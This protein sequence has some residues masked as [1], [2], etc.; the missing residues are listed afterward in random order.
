MNFNMFLPG[1]KDVQIT[2]IEEKES[3][4]SVHLQM[5]RQTQ[6]C[7]DCGGKTSKIHDYRIQKIKH[8]KWFE[9]PTYLFYKRRRYRCACGKRFAET[10]PFVERYQ[11]FSEEGNQA[12][13]IRS[14]KA[15]TFKEAAEVMGTSSS[16]VIRRFEQV[17]QK[18]LAAGV[19]LPKVIAI[20]EYKGDTN[21]GKFQLIVAN[22]ET[23][24]PLDILP[25]R[26]KET[27]KA[28]LRKYGQN[29][30][31]VV[32]DMSTSFRAAVREALGRPV[33][34]ADR[35]HY[36]RYIY[37]ALDKVRRDV[38]KD[39]HAY[40]RKKCKKMRHVF[41]KRPEKLREEDQFYLTRYLE[42]SPTLKEAYELKK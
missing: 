7:P 6:T 18:E 13:C 20:D 35:F 41:Y 14:I 17:A 2:S 29:V 42:M 24:E 11:R 39:W 31:M 32:M 36:C 9:R 23:R 33:I 37:W 5:P 8:L 16:T 1:M 21:E 19:E 27:I 4:I 28:Y 15:K 22:A 40:D 38:Q 34:I 30:E 25:N 12:L 26:R 3:G 10:V